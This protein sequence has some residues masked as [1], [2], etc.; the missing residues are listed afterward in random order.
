M[1]LVL[2]LMVLLIPTAL[3]LTLAVTGLRNDLRRR[4]AD[5]YFQ[6]GPAILEDV[7]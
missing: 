1:N 6:R 4:R 2:L 7:T 3:G 5:P